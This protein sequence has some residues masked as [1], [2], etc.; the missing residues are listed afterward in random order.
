M[1]TQ[2]GPEAPKKLF[3]IFAP[4]EQPRLP[5]GKTDNTHFNEIGARLVAGLAVDEMKRLDLPVATAFA[6]PQ[7]ARQAGG[8]R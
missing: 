6:D 7:S 1:V 8:S 5:E 4:G 3:V 2:H